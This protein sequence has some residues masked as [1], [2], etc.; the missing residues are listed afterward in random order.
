MRLICCLV[1]PLVLAPCFVLRAEDPAVTKRFQELLASEWE[2]GLRESPTFASHLGDKRYN[3]RW[4]DVSLAAIARRQQHRKDLLATLDK[5]DSSQLADDDQLNYQLF[6][7]E[8]A[9]VV[10]MIPF[11][12]YLI[13]ITQRGGIQTENETADSLIFRSVKDYEDWIARLS[14]FPA[15]MDQTI[16]LLR[17]GAKEKIVQPK[18]VMRRL[19]DQIKKQI[20]EE[21]AK[22]PYFKPFEKF[23]GEINA[24]DQE[25]LKKD[26]T[27]AI[28]D[29]VVPAYRKFAKFF[30]DEYYLACFDQVGAWQLPRGDEYYTIRAKH[31]T[32]TS[33]TP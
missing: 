15:Y 22:S 25:R 28:R 24:A 19:P 23:V 2:Y 29:H 17:T 5:I 33:M 13:A 20:V 16:E 1:M 10:E 4:P 7:K 12:S 11:R 3:D 6:R 9:G 14:S 32:T 21:P 27:A 30:D 18:I 8:A 26:A 31:F